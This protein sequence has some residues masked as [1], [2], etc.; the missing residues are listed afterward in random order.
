MSYERALEI[1]SLKKDF[2]EEEYKKRYHAL[3][4]ENHPDTV[5]VN[6]LEKEE[7]MKEINEAKIII[8]KKLKTRKLEEFLISFKNEI[9]KLK[10]KYKDTEIYNLS[11]LFEKKLDEIDSYVEALEEKKE[12]YKIITHLKKQ[13]ILPKEKDEFLKKIK[14]YED[15]HGIK[16]QNL[17]LTYISLVEECD[18]LEN[19]NTLNQKFSNELKKYL[20]EE[21]EQE[22]VY[23]TYRDNAKR[24][25]LFRFQEHSL[26]TTIEHTLKEYNLLLASLSLLLESNSNNILEICEFLESIDYTNPLSEISRVELYYL[27]ITGKINMKNFKD[28]KKLSTVVK[29]NISIPLEQKKQELLNKIIKQFYKYSTNKNISFEKIEKEKIRFQ[30]LLETIETTPISKIE[31]LLDNYQNQPYKRYKMIIDSM[32]DFLDPTKVYVDRSNGELCVLKEYDKNIYSI[33]LN[34]TVLKNAL[35]KREIFWKYITLANFFRISFYSNGKMLEEISSRNT[36]SVFD[37][38]SNDLYYTNDL[39]LRYI[40]DDQGMK[41]YFLPA[42]SGFHFQISENDQMTKNDFFKEF[43]DRDTCLMELLLFI[44]REQKEEKNTKSL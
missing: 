6:T 41:F 31:I 14:K 17:V 8:E 38:N 16:I 27:K 24:V 15:G 29:K 44:K 25:L 19:L 2:T 18:S 11:L 20:Q 42:K 26:N 33:Y 43:Q 30:E 12:F 40:E 34:G 3:A 32:D 7:R 36:I 35:E 9:Q 21:K 22:K 10:E 39:L 4:K 13:I 37:F 1:F 23:L 28:I 5:V